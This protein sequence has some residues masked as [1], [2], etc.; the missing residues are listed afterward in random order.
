MNDQPRLPF[1]ITIAERFEQF[2]ADNPEVYRVLVRLAREW[3][4]RTGRR[5]LGIGA[6][7]ER[8]R[9]EIAIATNDPDYKINNNY[10]AYYARLMMLQERDL[11]DIFDLRESEADEWILSQQVRIMRLYHGGV[12]DLRVG[13]VIEPGHA[14]RTHEGCEFCEARAQGKTALD[15]SGN[16]IDGP[17]QRP[18]RVYATT[19]RLYA[20]H[21]ASLWGRGD[22][23]R[24]TTAG[25]VDESTED[26]FESYCAERLIVAGIL[27][28]AVLLTN[29]ER[30]R[31]WREWGEA[32]KQR[33]AS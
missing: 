15:A 3:I 31:L 27:D 20:K 30:R 33:V 26:S 13:D 7:T 19:H 5:H 6:L 29:S 14:R 21:Y 22:L 2:H 16:L 12:P 8:T 23:Y 10:R 9:W 4:N 32:D 28:R 11:R 18:D 25:A 24:V 17:S 1:G